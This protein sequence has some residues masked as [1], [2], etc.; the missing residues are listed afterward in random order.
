MSNLTEALTGA[1]EVIAHFIHGDGIPKE[2]LEHLDEVSD[3]EES[4]AVREEGESCSHLISS[5]HNDD[6]LDADDL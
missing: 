4:R 3:N 1:I 2:S 6:H 5:V